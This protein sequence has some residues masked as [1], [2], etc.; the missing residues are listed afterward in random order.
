MCAL[1]TLLLA[2]AGS[3][4][5]QTV[6][7]T[8][9][10]TVTDSSGA[11]IPNATI[12]VVEVNTS[13]S[14]TGTT[15][16]SGNYTFA[17]LPPGTYSITAELAGFKR[18]SQARV[19][20][21]VN[22]TERVD[23][24]LQPGNVSE[25]VEVTTAAPMLQTDRADTGRKIEIVQAANLPIGTN[26]NFQGLLNLVPGTTR[27]GFQHSQFF[28]AASSLQTEVNGQLRMGNNYQLEGIDDNERTGLLQI[29]IPP[30][31]AIQ[32]VDVSTS[33]F[34][35]ELGRASGAVTNVFFKSGTNN[36]HG[37][38]Y[39]FLKNNDLN[40][41]NFFDP[42]VGHL[43]YNYFGGNIGGPIKKNKLFFFAD[44]LRVSDH[45]ANTNLLSIPTSDFRT[46]N[47][48]ASTTP[49]YDPATGN[50]DGTGRTP[51]PGNIIPSNRINPISAK[52]LSLIPA[53]TA[54]GS[55]NNFFGLLPF[56]KDTN[57][58]D[59]KVDYVLSDRDRLSARFS[60]SRPVVS[61]APV[62]GLAGGPAQG[63]FEGT[64]IQ[65]TYSAGLNYDRVF[66][67][68]LV[69]EFRFGVAY[70]HNEAKQ[71]DYG[72]TASTAI[73]IP[74][75]NLDANTSGLV[76]ITINGGVYNNPLLGYA[77]SLPWVRAEA[78]IDA[79]NTW[80]KTI[81]NHTLKF[82]GD[83]R[84]IR[85][86]LLQNQTFSPRG[87]Y[88][89]NDGQTSTPGAKTSFANNF[90]SFLLDLPGQAG[91]DLSVTFPNYRAY[92]F[93]TFVADK[94]SVTPKLTVDLGLRWELYPPATPA[95]PGGFSNYNPTNN[96]LV[97]AGI[98][99]NPSNLGL[100][101]RYT[102]F[103]PRFG[104]A[105][106]VTEKTVVRIGFGISYTPFPD[107]NWA[108][109]FPIRAN[110]AYDPAVAGYGPAVLSDGRVAT[111][112]NGFPQSTLPTIPAN[113]IITNP[114]VATNY[115]TVA[116]NFRNPY[117]ESWNVAIQQA[118]PAHFV[119]D[120]AYVANHGVN[121][122]VNYNLNASTSLNTGNAGLPEAAFGRKASTSQLFAGYSSLYNSLQIKLDRRFSSGLAVTTAYTFAKGMGF[123][124]GDDGG[125][126]FYINQRRNYA[127]NDFDRTNTF[128]QSYVYD[129][130]FG[131]G[132]KYLN[133]S[134]PASYVLGGWRVSGILSLMSGLPININYSATSLNSPGNSNSP[135][136]IAPVK[137]LHGI[138]VGN[139]WLTQASFQAP[140]VGVFG[141]VGRNSLNGPAFFDLDASLFKSIQFTERVSLELRCEAFGITNT[142]QF[143]NPGSTFGSANFGFITGTLGGGN[144]GTGGGRV[145]QL[146]A[147]FIF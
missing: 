69:A 75:I 58:L 86:A 40:A 67:P 127:R 117:V 104:A 94:W 99:G 39:E 48:S 64:G 111:F 13:S 37:A 124:T 7:A 121:N 43:A 98:G 90:A 84:R 57:S 68:S 128:V 32:T 77:A 95:F 102:N 74:G 66:S 38:A 56:T 80:T 132:K 27:A 2:L 89:F 118:L 123:Q 147:K 79:V 134:G 50:P 85:D 44:F 116:Q 16:E 65:N 59:A 130:P 91:R 70:Y 63:N 141:N 51:F 131:K 145:L 45:E 106:R 126:L 29:L 3:I 100:E 105:Y 103:A 15:N 137:I 24:T 31:E 25:T 139:P 28:N 22:T 8:L 5:S 11:T 42:K 49:I 110:N 52:L 81:G 26:R 6:T 101:A 108:Y 12:T 143:A 97:I 129:L 41:R 125:L 33:N 14:R 10:G 34:D 96:T 23:L 146:G 21:I 120:A 140:A 138:N 133:G 115:F 36:F 113:G 87:L 93:F 19:D 47:L 109:N 114:P 30:I 9:V 136:Q 62:F 112:Q 144:G 55:T 20:V 53:P 142:P 4:Y 88:T 119:L 76:G 78:N 1:A 83:I 18:A 82:G 35:A 135:D 17:N 46:G 72:S 73:G 60:Y 107:N 71:T 54:A 92:Q 61:Q 122:P